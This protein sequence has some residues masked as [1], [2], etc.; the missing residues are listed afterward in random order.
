MPVAE[1]EKGWARKNN[2][3]GLIIS[4]GE[5]MVEIVLEGFTEVQDFL[6]NN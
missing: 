3:N 5:Q 4:N 6:C 2:S 1:K